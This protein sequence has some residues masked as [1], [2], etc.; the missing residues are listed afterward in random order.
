MPKD[1]K[2][3]R[4]I[5]GLLD[6]HCEANGEYALTFT[7]YVVDFCETTQSYEQN[8]IDAKIYEVCGNINIE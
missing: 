1:F 3:L 2:C 4:R 8:L 7:K 6:T 5:N